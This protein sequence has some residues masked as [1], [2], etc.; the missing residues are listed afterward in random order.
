MDLSSCV[1]CLNI[2]LFIILDY[3][4][5]KI[6]IIKVKTNYYM[7][8]S[9]GHNKF[10]LLQMVEIMCFRWREKW[11]MIPWMSIQS[12]YNSNGKPEICSSNMWACYEHSQKWRHQ[13]AEDMFYWM[14]INSS[15]CNR[16]CPLMVLLVYMFVQMS[17][18]EQPMSNNLNH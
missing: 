17:T 3:L 7:S 4:A 8:S 2:C 12:R 16:S 1:R 6:F 9:Y 14:T 10:Y 11:P 18:M 13:I 15:H 5:N